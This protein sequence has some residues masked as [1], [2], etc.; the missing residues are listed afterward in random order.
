MQLRALSKLM[1]LSRLSR[2]MGVG[3]VFFTLHSSLLTFGRACSRSGKLKLVWLSSLLIAAFIFT[4]CSSEQAGPDPEQQGVPIQ[5]MSYVTPFVDN[6][7]EPAESRQLSTFN[8]Q[9]S[10]L[11]S[12]LSTL[13][14][15]AWTLPEGYTE[16]VSH[17]AIGA[18]FT[19]G[20]GTCEP[21]RFWY[22][23]NITDTWTTPKWFINGK[24]ITP[25]E[26][27]IYGYMPNNAAEVTISPND[28]YD[29]GAILHFTDLG[30][31]MAKD[32]C[33]LVAAKDGTASNVTD[34][35]IG[36]FLCNMKSGGS[37]GNENYL[38]LLFEHI[39]AR[40]EFRFCMDADYAKLRIIKLK[41]LELTAYTSTQPNYSGAVKMKKS[42]TIDVH[43]TANN[44]NSSPIADDIRF[45]P[46]SDE[47]MDPVLIFEGEET[48][49]SDSYTTET[50]YVPY[51]NFA[52]ANTKVLYEL[53]SYYDVYDRQG[54]LIRKNCEAVNDIKPRVL[55]GSEQLDCGKQYIIN[56]TVAPTYLYVMSEPDLDNPTIQ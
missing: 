13:N 5:L 44:E 26:F 47:D 11:N 29:K 30:S 35:S 54:N 19:K 31:I 12:Q 49:P 17:K 52:D 9:L 6:S 3:L 28:T 36:Q 42:G 40:L 1:R 41:K 10:T 24:S 46:T 20:D 18:F 27:Y 4:S 32:V 51:F 37:A 15:R 55:F 50:G 56:L 45:V 21:H 2:L 7:Q 25:G 53:H 34:F 22:N 38:Y 48:M 23:D 8:S 43:L 14:T 33:V 39:Y 16:D